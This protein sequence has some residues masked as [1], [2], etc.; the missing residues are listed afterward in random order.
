[1]NERRLSPF[2]RFVTPFSLFGGLV[3]VSA[4]VLLAG[5]GTAAPKPQSDVDA[6]RAYGYL[7]K[8]CRI[9]TRVSGTPAMAQQ[10]KVIA[11]HFSKLGAKI[12]FQT[13]DTAHPQSG[14][15]VRMSNIIV[16]WHPEAKQRVLL[17]CH[18][19]TRPFPDRDRFNPRG[20][21]IG[22]NDGGSGV[23]L[24]MELGHHMQELKP[25]Y[26]VDFVFFDGE[27]L[28]YS[29]DDQYFLGSEY[30]AKQYRAE[31]PAHRY[32]CGVLVDMIADRRL[33][34]YM[35][36]NSFKFAPAVTR[37]IWAAAR[38]LKVREFHGRIKHEVRDDH[39]PLNEIARI[40]TCDIIDFDYPY[41]HT[42]NDVPAQCSGGSIAKVGRVLLHW[43]T[44]VPKPTGN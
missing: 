8:V 14:N 19:D 27:E 7:V 5:F 30:F 38:D 35:E 9:G 32:V 31:P 29:R 12:S 25:T 22:A 28:V 33:D 4:I 2:R 44:Q 40:P 13:F 1:M 43:L 37:S 10:Q 26:G 18:Y 20:K 42:T 6:R 24:F 11:E 17:A 34:L 3:I 21:F 39:I 15:A 16:S 36:K 23:A 41:W